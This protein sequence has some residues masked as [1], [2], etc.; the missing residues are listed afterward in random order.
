MFTFFNC[1]CEA[2]YVK[3]ISE[4]LIWI[5]VVI[6]LLIFIALTNIH[7]LKLKARDFW[8]IY[9]R[10]MFFS[11][12]CRNNQIFIQVMPESFLPD[13]YSFALC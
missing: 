9:C 13:N 7:H 6:S 11:I 2:A 5:F 8:I 12:S 1:V 10:S 4:I 3:S